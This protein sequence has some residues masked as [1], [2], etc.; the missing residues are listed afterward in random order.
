[1]PQPS[2]TPYTGPIEVGMV[3]DFEPGKKHRYERMT[4]TKKV[5]AQLWCYGRSAETF[6]EEPEFRKSVVLV[7][8]K[9]L[10]KPRPKPLPLEKRYDGPI[11]PGMVFDFE[12]GKKHMYERLTIMK[13]EGSQLWAR[14]RSGETFYEEDEFRDHVVRATDV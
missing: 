11:E 7:S 1:M 9:S 13:R 12:P 10:H 4:V 5:G 8:E 6:H 2:I 14:G 3:F